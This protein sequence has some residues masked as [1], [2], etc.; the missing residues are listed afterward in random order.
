[1]TPEALHV[2]KEDLGEQ[3]QRDHALLDARAAA[4]VEPDHRAAGLHRVV[5]DLDDLLAVDL[6]EA[7]A[8]DREVLAEHRDRPAVHRAVPGDHAV[9]VGAVGL[10]TELVRAVP[11][12][13]VELN[14][15]SRVQQQLN[16][17]AGGQLAP[18]VLL[19][20]GRRG[21]RVHGLVPAGLQ[22]GDL[23]RSCVNIRLLNRGRA[24]HANDRN[25]RLGWDYSGRVTFTG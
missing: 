4:V 11:G 23:A 24:G 8:E 6:A 9:P 18:G 2:P 3:A 12:Q 25:P 15:R 21:P 16:P 10:D 13:F 1:M 20:H 22:V 17:L 5:H 19:L 14:E 7:A